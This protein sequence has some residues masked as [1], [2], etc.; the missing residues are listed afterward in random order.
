MP[1]TPFHFGIAI[2]LFGIMPFLDPL[3]LFVSVIIPDIEGITALFILPYSGLPL[4]GPLHSFLG[5]IALGIVTGGVSYLVLKIFQKYGIIPSQIHVTLSKS[6]FSAFLGTISHI[7]LDAPLYSEMNPFLPFPG[8]PLVGLVP[9]SFPYLVCVISFLLGSVILLI[10]LSRHHPELIKWFEIIKLMRKQKVFLVIAVPVLLISV[11]IVL[12]L[13]VSFLFF[14]AYPS[15][16]GNFEWNDAC[17]GAEVSIYLSMDDGLWRTNQ[18]RK[19]TFLFAVDA[20]NGGSNTTVSYHNSYVILNTIKLDPAYIDAS[21]FPFAQ[22]SDKSG[23]ST[24]WYFTPKANDPTLSA[25][26]ITKTKRIPYYLSLE[27]NYTVIDSESV[28]WEGF[29]LDYALI[30][31]IGGEDA[32]KLLTF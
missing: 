16:T 13:V 21:E 28:E 29:F 31:F 26:G 9:Q 12:P 18:N 1:F 6:M 10:R 5:A 15:G 19:L 30:T 23:W 27:V 24:D 8:N 2:L 14:P 32:P 7:L 3:A 22:L 4:H 20:I 25:M 11:I 17:H